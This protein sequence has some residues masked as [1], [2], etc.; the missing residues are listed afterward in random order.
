[1]RHAHFFYG[2]MLCGA[3]GVAGFYGLK[4]YYDV[5]SFEEFGQA[6]RQAVPR[7]R[8]E[9]ETGLGPLLSRIRSR[10]SDSLPGPIVKMREKFQQSRTGIWMRSRFELD[11]GSDSGLQERKDGEGDGASP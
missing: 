7:R 1:M 5:D 9:I 6:M 10:A 11:I 3:M 4:W 8:R 2:T